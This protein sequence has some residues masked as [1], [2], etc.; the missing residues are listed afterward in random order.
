VA[1]IAPCEKAPDQKDDDG[2][3]D[4]ADQSRAFI[5]LIPAD[6]LP[7]LGRDEGTDDPQNGSQDKPRGFIR[8]GVEKF[9]NNTRNEADDDSP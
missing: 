5:G 8:P 9:G 2:A 4:G 1:A 6:R 7:D 3:Y